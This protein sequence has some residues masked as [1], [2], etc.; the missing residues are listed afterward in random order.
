MMEFEAN[1]A[2]DYYRESAPLVAMIHPQSRASLKALIGIYSRLLDKIVA[3]N[4]DVLTRRI[5]VPT[6]EKMWILA[7]SKFR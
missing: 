4:Y 6:W 3:S 1:R 7:A 5:R 2:R